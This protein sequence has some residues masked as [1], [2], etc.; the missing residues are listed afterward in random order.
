MRLGLTVAEAPAGR[1]L[2]AQDPS[3]GAVLVK[4]KLL[5]GLS[6]TPQARSRSRYPDRCLDR[7]LDRYPTA[8]P[9]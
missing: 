8:G 5:D 6:R 2:A 7:Y 3:M 4:F 1:K 9:P